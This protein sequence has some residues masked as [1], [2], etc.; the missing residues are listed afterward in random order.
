MSH[1]RSGQSLVLRSVRACDMCR[2]EPEPFNRYAVKTFGLTRRGRKGLR[3][4]CLG[5]MKGDEG[6]WLTPRPFV[7][8]FILWSTQPVTRLMTRVV[9][10]VRETEGGT[11]VEKS[12]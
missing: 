4:G 6:S 8:L 11:L 10:Q 12:C 5:K 2:S 3:L 1:N 9:G 7:R